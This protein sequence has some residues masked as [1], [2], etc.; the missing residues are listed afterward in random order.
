MNNHLRISKIMNSRQLAAAVRGVLFTREMLPFVIPSIFQMQMKR[1]DSDTDTFSHVKRSGQ[2][3][4]G[5]LFGRISHGFGASF[6]STSPNFKNANR[7]DAGPRYF[8]THPLFQC[9]VQLHDKQSQNF[10]SVSVN[11]KR[12]PPARG[13]F[14]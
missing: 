10:V 14:P 13:S 11:G 5:Y 9:R 8:N 4:A 12:G 3:A 1:Y 2:P 7:K 6:S